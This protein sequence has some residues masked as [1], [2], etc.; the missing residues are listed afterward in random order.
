MPNTLM[1]SD[2]AAAKI[3]ADWL[4]IVNEGRKHPLTKAEAITLFG[5][6][7]GVLD[8]PR[9]TVRALMADKLRD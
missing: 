4:A 8:V 1:T 9:E 3:T 2:E 5:V 6:A 7:Y